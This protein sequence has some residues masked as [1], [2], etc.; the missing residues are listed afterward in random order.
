MLLGQRMTSARQKS[1]LSKIRQA[2]TILFPVDS[3]AS[4]AP[5][6]DSGLLGMVITGLG[7]ALPKRPCKKTTKNAKNILLSVNYLMF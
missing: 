2:G 1:K 7:L 6:V 5:Q 4:T 3:T